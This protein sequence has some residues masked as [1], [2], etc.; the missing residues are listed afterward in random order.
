MTR[1]IRAAIDAARIADQRISQW[2]EKNWKRVVKADYPDFD[3]VATVENMQILEEQMPEITQLIMKAGNKTDMAIATYKAIKRM[4]K[5]NG[6]SKEIAEN[7]KQ[8]EKNKDKPMSTAAVDKR[9]IAQVARY[10]DSDY[11]DLWKEMNHYASKA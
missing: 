7:K 11:E 2:E 3:E 6:T 1:Y 8:L 4:E 10:S 9:P 5:L